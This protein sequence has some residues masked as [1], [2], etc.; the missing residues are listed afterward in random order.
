MGTAKSAI[1]GNE[2]GIGGDVLGQAF[3]GGYLPDSAAVRESADKV[4]DAIT[5]DA[6]LGNQAVGDYGSTDGG[7]AAEF[8]NVR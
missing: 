1:A 5:T 4:P 3:R 8:G 6:S 2:G 7:A